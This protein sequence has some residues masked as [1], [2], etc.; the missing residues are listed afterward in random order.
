MHAAIWVQQPPAS[1]QQVRLDR[2]LTQQGGSPLP[3]VDEDIWQKAIRPRHRP[4]PPAPPST[5]IT[6][7]DWDPGEDPHVREMEEAKARL[8]ERLVSAGSAAA[9]GPLDSFDD[10]PLLAS[11]L[12]LPPRRAPLRRPGP[13]LHL[14]RP[15]VAPCAALR[16]PGFERQ[17]D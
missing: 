7:E 9:L 15:G 4:A 1:D 8:V 12:L 5:L 16:G 17:L 2:W 3:L 6:A 11:F 10:L 14:P 13:R